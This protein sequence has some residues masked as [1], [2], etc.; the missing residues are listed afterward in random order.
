MIGVKTMAEKKFKNDRYVTRGIAENLNP[1]LVVLLWEM[2]DNLSIKQDYLQVFN[3][4]EKTANKRLNTYMKN[5]NTDRSI[6]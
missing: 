3:L 1:L 6:W 5:L 2:I 4:S